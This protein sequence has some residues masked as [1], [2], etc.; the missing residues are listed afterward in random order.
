MVSV[1][2]K[3]LYQVFDNNAEITDMYHE[4]KPDHMAVVT[5][6][7]NGEEFRI[8]FNTNTLRFDPSISVRSTGERSINLCLPKELRSNYKKS[9]NSTSNLNDNELNNPTKEKKSM[10]AEKLK[11]KVLIEYLVNEKSARSIAKNLPCSKSKVSRILDEKGVKKH[12]RT[13]CRKKRMSVS[14]DFFKTTVT[15]ESDLFYRDYAICVLFEKYN[16]NPD[17]MEEIFEVTRTRIVDI[18]KK[19]DYKPLT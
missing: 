18:L 14:D 19:L 15:P 9:R 13:N 6:K 17:R 1:T 12:R 7:E 4:V 11:Q 10:L 8:P 2:T 5:V 16:Y 3:T